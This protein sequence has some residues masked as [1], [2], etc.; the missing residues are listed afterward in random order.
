MITSVLSIIG[1]LR[2]IGVLSITGVV[3]NR[4]TADEQNAAGPPRGILDALYYAT[5][6]FRSRSNK[7]CLKRNH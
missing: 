4:Y 5:D 1:V 7:Q 3:R 2:M 6:A